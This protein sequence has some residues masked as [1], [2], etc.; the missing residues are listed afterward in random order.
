MGQGVSQIKAS[1]NHLHETFVMRIKLKEWVV[2]SRRPPSR[3]A[4][5][6]N[7]VS[8]EGEEKAEVPLR[9]GC[10]SPPP[11]VGAIGTALKRPG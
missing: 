8:V 2:D 1:T 9:L 5:S 10:V 3:W 7:Y 6:K 4:V 11:V